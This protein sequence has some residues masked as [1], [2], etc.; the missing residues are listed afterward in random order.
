MPKAKDTFPEIDKA[1]HE[2]AR[3]K[4]IATLASVEDGDMT[5]LMNFTGLSWGNL[6]VQVSKL[7]D[8]GY[9]DVQKNFVNNKPQS[10]VCLTLKG[11]KAFTH[12][13]ETLGDLLDV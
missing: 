7:K 12:Y 13:K 4:I 5:F 8:I 3:L 10:K 2:L 1:I 11:K 6:S 9:V